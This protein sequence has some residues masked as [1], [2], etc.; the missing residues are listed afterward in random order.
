[1]MYLMGDKVTSEQMAIEEFYDDLNQGIISESRSREMVRSEAFFENICEELIENA[2]LSSEYDFAFY[3]D[4]GVEVCGYSYDEE[5][6]IL[7]LMVS[8]YFQ[9]DD[10]EKIKIDRTK[11]TAKFKRLKKFLDIVLNES[12]NE[13]FPDNEVFS[14]AH[15]IL[16]K[17]KGYD[18]NDKRRVEKFRFYLITNGLNVSTQITIDNL[19]I[20][21]E[22]DVIPIEHRVI[23]LKYMY[24]TYTDQGV[25]KI[26]IQTSIPYLEIDSNN[27]EYS[28]YLSVM[29]GSQIV[30]IYEEYGQQLLEQNVRTFLMFR[31]KVNKGLRETIKSSP[32][33]F[34]AYNNGITGTASDV[35]IVDGKITMLKDFQIV[36]GG[37]TTSAIYSCHKKDNID[38]SKINV[39]LKLSVIKKQE[40]HSDFVSRVAR[41]ANTQNAIQD[42]DFFSN[43]PFH[44][45]FKKWSETV[46]C[47]EI[48]GNQFRTKWYYERVRGEY[49]NDQAYMTA[50]KK[51]DFLLLYP[52]TDKFDKK[53]LSKP[54]ISWQQKPHIV[55]KGVSYSFNELA[56]TVT[57]EIQKNNRAITE[58]YYKHTVARVIMFKSLEKLISSSDWYEGGYRAQT[59]TY[60]MAY[61]SHIVK[62]TKKHFNFDQIWELQA[63]PRDVEQILKK[64]APKVYQSITD[65]DNGP[66]NKAQWAKKEKCWK[67][68]KEDLKIDIDD[69]ASFLVSQTIINTQARE[70]EQDRAFV[71][72]VEK[73]SFVLDKNNANIWKPLLERYKN[74]LDNSP[75]GLSILKRFASGL[76]PQPS[77]KQAVIIYDIY[78]EAI[79]IGWVSPK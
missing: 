42:A 2:E 66:V 37:Q 65:P 6:K 50:S 13:T 69:D 15:N 10:F 74:E 8:S 33:R 36:N 43:S 57:D 39:Q 58:A 30:E 41:Y 35:E 63:L 1:M 21:V 40:E 11:I 79:D 75:K 14:M 62:N 16:E 38:V 46:K 18:D 51:R 48:G 25:K 12:I 29:S 32:E 19:E 4:T 55:S 27:E 72:S 3:Q 9:D 23:D 31:A 77:E 24:D 67:T 70:E 44:Q 26:E 28:S 64:I 59:V 22:D 53:F 52:K 49:Q 20:N 7:S 60:S 71:D 54:V 73:W 45:Q 56:V 61:L 17:V 34:F 68:V 5:R 78:E 76:L 47:P